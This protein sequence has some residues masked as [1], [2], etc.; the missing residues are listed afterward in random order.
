MTITRKPRRASR[1]WNLLLFPNLNW[2]YNFFSNKTLHLIMQRTIYSGI[3][4]LL[5]PCISL[6]AKNNIQWHYLTAETL[7]C[8]EQYAVA[9]F[10]CWNLASHYA[11][12]NMQ[13]DYST[14]ET[15]HLTLQGTICRGTI[16]LLKPCISLS[17]ERYAVGLFHCWNLASH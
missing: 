11:R 14:A 8:K 12:N 3:I 15:L 7:L 16:P 1:I 13:W 4:L 9:L 6:Y 2:C 10:Y 17:K 5:K